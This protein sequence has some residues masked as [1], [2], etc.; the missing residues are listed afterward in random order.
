M[1]RDIE[2]FQRFVSYLGLRWD[3]AEELMW[4]RRLSNGESLEKRE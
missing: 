2:E 3:R 1:A 4:Y